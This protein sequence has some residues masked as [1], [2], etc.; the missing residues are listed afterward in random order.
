ML[1]VCHHGS[2]VAV[3]ADLAQLVGCCRPAGAKAGGFARHD[4]CPP[5]AA[6]HIGQRLARP[7][8]LV[9]KETRLNN[10][11]LYQRHHPP[12][13][14]PKAIREAGFVPTLLIDRRDTPIK[15]VSRMV[16]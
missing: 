2:T 6:M 7:S 11:I 8:P 9:P 16:D 14:P 4:G 10:R 13:K 5:L 1:M 3:L 12:N 15:S